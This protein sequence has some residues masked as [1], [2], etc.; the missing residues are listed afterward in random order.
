MA[1][2]V[3]DILRDAIACYKEGDIAGAITEY[4]EAIQLE[5]DDA[6]LYANR[7]IGY[8]G[9]EQYENAITDYTEAIRL[10]PDKAEWH[11]GRGN[12]Y[13]AKGEYDNAMTDYTEALRLAPDDAE[14]FRLAIGKKIKELKGKIVAAAEAEKTEKKKDDRSNHHHGFGA[15]FGMTNGI[16]YNLHL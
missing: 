5:P 9:M 16:G 12:V 11:R 7:G 6:Y 1:E 15:P 10:M 8:L 4:T 3:I 2:S 13:R 14:S